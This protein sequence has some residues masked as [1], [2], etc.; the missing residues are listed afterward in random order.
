MKTIGF[1]ELNASPWKNGG[2]TTRELA[3]EPNGAS[4]ETLDW[5][6]SIADIGA[7]GPFSVF[8]GLDR[9]IVLLDGE[10]VRMEFDDGRVHDLTSPFEPYAFAGEQPVFARL[11]GE[12][13]RDFNVML[14]RGV[15]AG[16]VQV[17]RT[18]SSLACNAGSLLFFCA[19]GEW[20][21]VTPDG[22]CKRIALRQTLVG[23]CPPGGVEMRPLSG[24]AVLIGIN[25]TRAA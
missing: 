21:I 13:S 11:V 18:A 5:R 16:Q 9:I 22:S 14:R 2:G 23:D 12:A 1:D 15:V 17:W 3:I 24:N 6:A 8:P 20:E 7:S 25:L 10:G 4:F 19:D